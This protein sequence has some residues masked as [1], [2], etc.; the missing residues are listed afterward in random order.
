MEVPSGVNV[1]WHSYLPSMQLGQEIYYLHHVVIFYINSF[2]FYSIAPSRPPTNVQVPTISQRQIE[3]VWAPPPMDQQNGIIRRY[4]VNI[5]S[6]DGGEELITYSQTTS[7]LVQNLH[8]FTTYTCSVSAETV[9]PGP[10]SPPVVIQT[11]EDGKVYCFWI[12]L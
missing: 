12:N 6:Q 8:P 11:P 4:I 2:F 5:T 9:A 1:D 7:T 3:L 10:F